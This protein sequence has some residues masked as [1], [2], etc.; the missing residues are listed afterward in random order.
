MVRLYFYGNGNIKSVSDI[1]TDAGT[2]NEKPI[3]LK[4][5]HA[6]F[7]EIDLRTKKYDLNIV[8]ADNTINLRTQPLATLS[9]TMQAYPI[10]FNPKIAFRLDQGVSDYRKYILE[11]VEISQEN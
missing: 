7:V 9:G 6:V 8:T 11:S 4:K 2:T 5:A 1:A 10:P 3:D